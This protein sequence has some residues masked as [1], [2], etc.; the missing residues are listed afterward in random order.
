VIV[1][2]N[3]FGDIITDLGAMIQAAWAW[4]RAATSTRTKAEPPVRTDRRLG[5]EVHGKTSSIPSPASR[6]DR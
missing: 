6:R 3:I 5:A 4:R 1:T 2:G